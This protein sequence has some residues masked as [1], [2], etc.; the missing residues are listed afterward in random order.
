MLDKI[1]DLERQLKAL[2]HSESVSKEKV[3]LLIEMAEAFNYGDDPMR[4]LALSREAHQLAQSLAYRAGMARALFYA[5]SASW[6]MSD[7]EQALQWLLESRSLFEELKDEEG[8]A[9]TAIIISSVHRSMGEYDQSFLDALQAAT[10]FRNL[11][12]QY[13]EGGCLAGSW[14]HLSSDRGF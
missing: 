11:G 8:S 4:M 3:D 7:L 12:D 13:W 5:G 1:K 6:F 9:R 10:F 14:G 2:P